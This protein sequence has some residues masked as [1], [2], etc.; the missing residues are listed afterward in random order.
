MK[1]IA[2]ILALALILSVIGTAAF[3]APANTYTTS[4]AYL[5]DAGGWWFNNDVMLVLNDDGATYDLYFKQ[6]IFGTTD[7]GIKG[8]KTVIYSGNYSSAASADGDANHM[9]ITLDTVDRIY[10]EQHEKAFGRQE[11]VNYPAVLDT[12][13]WTE[14]YSDVVAMCTAD[15]FLAE[16]APNAEGLVITIED[17]MFDIDNVELSTKIVALPFDMPWDAEAPAVPLDIAR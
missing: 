8:N 6:D 5:V 12:A 2:R 10:V 7:P 4:S 15:E 17:V 3:A 11:I 14:D 13:N 9:D 1:N 16:Y